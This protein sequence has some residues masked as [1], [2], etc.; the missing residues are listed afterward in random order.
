MIIDN[1]YVFVESQGVAA[2]NFAMESE[3][4]LNKQGLFT[5]ELEF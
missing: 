2:A 5:S 1:D 3:L 4:L